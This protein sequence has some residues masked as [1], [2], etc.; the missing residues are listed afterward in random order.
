MIEVSTT[1]LAGAGRHHLSV[2][3]SEDEVMTSQV[4]IR[5]LDGERGIDAALRSNVAGA[6]ERVA[7][8]FVESSVNLSAGQAD[9]EVAADSLIARRSTFVVAGESG[10]G[11]RASRR[12]VRLSV[13][14]LHHFPRRCPFATSTRA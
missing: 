11:R 8:S 3:R 13:S 9:V 12:A 10:G 2:G 4:L 7:L 1:S 5:L 14:E 6:A